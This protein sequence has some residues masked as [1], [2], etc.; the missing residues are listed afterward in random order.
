MS[1]GDIPEP[2]VR[3]LV[4]D[5]FERWR[6]HIFTQLQARRD[7]LIVGEA[8]DGQEAV[9]KAELLKPDLI[10]LDV[11]LHNM[12]GITA[13]PL[14]SCAAPN[15]KILFVSLHDRPVMVRAALVA[16]A[17]G[18]LVKS[19]AA[20]ELLRAIDQVLK[21]NLFIDREIFAA[22]S[23][24]D[25]HVVQFYEDD[26]SLATLLGGIVTNALRSEQSAIVIATKVHRD[27]LDEQLQ[28]Q[29]VDVR[30]HIRDGSYIVQDANEILSSCMHAGNPDPA[31]FQAKL[32]PLVTQA[33]AASPIGKV[34]IFGEMGPLLLS[35]GNDKSAL[36]LEQFGSELARDPSVS[37]RC[38]YH[39]N[40]F[41]ASEHRAVC[42]SICAEHSAIVG[43]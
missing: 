25:E 6:R 7:L 19:H 32:N 28:S 22:D 34:V 20:N 13:A 31:K 39:A 18:Y 42:A 4:V 2:V 35:S 12:N 21:G 3:I 23:T 24:D 8:A 1:D 37:V 9:R 10:L 33:Q 15:S 40:A 36:K 43:A 27:A 41:S 26:L 16:G 29:G 11:S 5:D 14:L 38:A 17:H 30:G